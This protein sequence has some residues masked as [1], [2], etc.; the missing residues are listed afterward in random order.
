MGPSQTLQSFKDQFNVPFFMEAIIIMAWAIWSVRNDFIF[1]GIHPS[2]QGA[3]AKFTTEW[4]L[5]L[6]R[7]KPSYH[8]IIDLWTANLL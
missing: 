8:P 3:K 5:L 2:F 7:T 4:R 6:Y 1:R